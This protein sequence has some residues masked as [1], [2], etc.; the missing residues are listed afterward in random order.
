MNEKNERRLTISC[1]DCAMQCSSAC[2]DCVVSFILSDDPATA[3]SGGEHD[4]VVLDLEQARVVRL[5]TQ[6]GM[7]PDLK[8]DVAG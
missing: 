2:A 7:I 5:F 3:G 1:D 6:A 4:T 8:F